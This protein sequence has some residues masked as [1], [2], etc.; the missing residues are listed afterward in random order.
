V[1]ANTS[2]HLHFKNLFVS[3]YVLSKYKLKNLDKFNVTNVVISIKM[4]CILLD[5]F[6][7]QPNNRKTQSKGLDSSTSIHPKVRGSIFLLDTL[8]FGFWK[9]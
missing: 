5:N 6:N 1:K 3:T 4:L 2:K 8:V 7:S 9:N